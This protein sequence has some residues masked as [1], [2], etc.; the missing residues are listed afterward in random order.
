MYFDQVKVNFLYNKFE[1]LTLKKSFGSRL[2]LSLG[3][4]SNREFSSNPAYCWDQNVHT[5][6]L[7]SNDRNLMVNLSL[8]NTCMRKMIFQSKTQASRNNNNNNN[9]HHHPHHHHHHHIIIIIIVIIITIHVKSDEVVNIIQNSF[10]N[11]DMKQLIFEIHITEQEDAQR[12][13]RGMCCCK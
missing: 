8:V 3:Y 12:C 10:R 1:V 6:V 7:M 11:Y 4:F 13:L 5:V 2:V 9:H